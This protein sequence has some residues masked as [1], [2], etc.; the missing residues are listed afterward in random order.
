MA[1]IF[2]SWRTMLRLR[3]ALI[4][5]IRCGK[6][7]ARDV[8]NRQ[9]VIHIVDGDLKQYRRHYRARLV[10]LCAPHA[11]GP[12]APRTG[13]GPGRGRQPPAPPPPRRRGGAPQR[14]APA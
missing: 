6:V 3:S 14:A 2:I 12:R 7:V 4:S 10:L 5:V 1:F 9:T 11:A 13:G 8:V